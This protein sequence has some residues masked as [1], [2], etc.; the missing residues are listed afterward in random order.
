MEQNISAFRRNSGLSPGFPTTAAHWLAHL[1][2]P[3]EL[4]SQVLC[5]VHSI[6]L[7]MAVL[8]G[9]RKVLWIPLRQMIFPNINLQ[10]PRFAQFITETI[11]RPEHPVQGIQPASRYQRRKNCET[12][13]S[14]PDNLVTVKPAVVRVPSPETLQQ[15]PLFSSSTRTL[16][17]LSLKIHLPTSLTYRP[18]HQ[19]AIS[20]GKSNDLPRQKIN[21]GQLKRFHRCVL[22]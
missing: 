12:A 11:S 13:V 15:W 2:P 9:L 5:F 21:C 16:K 20:A 18:Y 1:E 14:Q 19:L 10:S 3:P 4:N 8:M 6:C 17:G 22:S 7:E